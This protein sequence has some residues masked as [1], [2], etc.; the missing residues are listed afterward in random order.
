MLNPKSL[1]EKDSIRRLSGE[2]IVDCLWDTR[3]TQTSGETDEHEI[4]AWREGDIIKAEVK[5]KN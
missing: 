4:K 2:L 1:N 3:V 5:R